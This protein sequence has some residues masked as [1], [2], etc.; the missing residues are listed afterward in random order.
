MIGT[1]QPRENSI[2]FQNDEAAPVPNPEVETACEYRSWELNP[3]QDRSEGWGSRRTPGNG[4]EQDIRQPDIP[5]KIG[6][7]GQQAGTS[8]SRIRIRAYKR[9]VNRARR[10]P[11]MYRGRQYTSRSVAR[12]VC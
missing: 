1:D 10:G 2:T 9:A 3:G 12:T 6:D 5:T 8:F 4:E 7:P 11:T